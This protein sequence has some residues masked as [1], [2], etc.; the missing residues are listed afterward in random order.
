MTRDI[1]GM[2]GAESGPRWAARA[3]PTPAN[4]AAEL[5]HVRLQAGEPSYR[6]IAHRMDR[7]MGRGYYSTTTIWRAFTQEK[8]PQWHIAAAILQALEVDRTYLTAWHEMWLRAR[9][10]E[11]ERRGGEPDAQQAAPAD[12]AHGT[13]AEG[14]RRLAALTAPPTDGPSQPASQVCDDCGALIGDLIRHQAW[15][16]R[17]ERQLSRVT[18]R[19]V[20]GTGQ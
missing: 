4:F 11:A 3:H 9:A 18:L 7:G 1:T 6:E 19:A 8:L 12:P 16:W 2:P 5:R 14:P 17:V 15:H 10:E 20:E 13:P